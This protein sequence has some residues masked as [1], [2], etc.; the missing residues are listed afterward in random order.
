[1]PIIETTLIRGYEP[2]AKARLG[3]ALTRAVCSV[4]AADPQAV[5]VVHREVDEGSWMRGGVARKPGPPL[6]AASEVVKAHVRAAT[7]AL[8]ERRY[9]AFEEVFGDDAVVVFASGVTGEGARVVD[10]FEV[11]QGAVT[12][13]ESWGG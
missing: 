7:D 8:G 2:E 6:P 12:H 5:I 11:R 4:V 1:M 3:L 10:R 9:A 13:V